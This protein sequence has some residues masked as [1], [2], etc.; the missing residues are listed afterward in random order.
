M[1]FTIMTP[2]ERALA[3]GHLILFVQIIVPD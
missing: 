1:P 3:L 2:L